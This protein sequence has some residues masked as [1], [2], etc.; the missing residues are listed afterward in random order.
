[1][2]IQ[3]VSLTYSHHQT[4]S[5]GGGI[6]ATYAIKL[7]TPFDATLALTSIVA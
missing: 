5:Y 6:F 7:I 2:W 4:K 3:N 1:M